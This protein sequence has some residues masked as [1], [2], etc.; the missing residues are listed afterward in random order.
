MQ[1]RLFVTILLALENILS[2]ATDEHGNDKDFF[3]TGEIVL[4]RE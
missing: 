2:E 1:F 3:A 4:P